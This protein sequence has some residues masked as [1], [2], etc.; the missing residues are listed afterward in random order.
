MDG[1]QEV[2]RSMDHEHEHML[3]GGTVSNFFLR[4]SL[5]LSHPVFVG[6]CYGLMISVALLLP[7]YYGDSQNNF[8]E[9]ARDWG[10]QSLVIVSMTSILGAFSILSST[11][12]KRPPARLQD[13]KKI[14]FVFP[15]I[16][17]SIVSISTIRGFGGEFFLEFGWFL[18]IL[19]GPLWVHLSYAPRWRIIE[20]IDRG[21]DPFEGMAKTIY[22]SN[23]RFSN[24]E[25]REL[26]EVVE[27]I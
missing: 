19:P 22:G 12:I 23:S 24:P 17:L 20:R 4:E 9:L 5:T 15:F 27:I 25:D 11:L 18:Y 26:D 16:G 21:L 1:W 14:L 8:V 7:L 13:W 2:V 6:G 10:L 3:R